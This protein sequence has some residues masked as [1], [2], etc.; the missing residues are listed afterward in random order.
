MATASNDDRSSK[1]E[2]QVS[3]FDTAKNHSMPLLP[4]NHML[5]A[6]PAIAGKLLIPH[7]GLVEAADNDEQRQLQSLLDSARRE[8]AAT[9]RAFRRAVVR[10]RRART[11]SNSSVADSIVSSASAA[12]SGTPSAASESAAS[13]ATAAAAT[14]A[15]AA[16]MA[17]MLTTRRATIA[18]APTA[19]SPQPT[20]MHTHPRVDSRDTAGGQ[21]APAPTWSE[22]EDWTRRSV[23][24][25]I[26]A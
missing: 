11:A 24:S 12:S 7:H 8:D 22:D 17:S 26:S 18:T 1:E 20:A 13:S 4:S 15:A 9:D 25:F 21:D 23:L 10:A 14:A 19:S 3:P 16:T 6:S 2:P 5:S